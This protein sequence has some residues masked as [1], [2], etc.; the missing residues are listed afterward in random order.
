MDRKQSSN[1]YYEWNHKEEEGFKPLPPYDLADHIPIIKLFHKNSKQTDVITIKE[2]FTGVHIFGATGSGKTSGS[3]NTF[4]RAMLYNGYGGAVFTVKDDEVNTWMGQGRRTGEYTGHI[5]AAGRDGQAIIFREDSSYTFNPFEYLKRF[6]KLYKLDFLVQLVGEIYRINK[7]AQGK[8]P[9]GSKN[10][11][12][13]DIRDEAI[14]IAIALLMVSEEKINLLQIADIIDTMPCTIEAAELYFKAKKEK[15]D[16]EFMAWLD[17]EDRY[18]LFCYYKA[19]KRPNKT[20][21][22]EAR[23]RDVRRYI[24]HEF[25]EM[26]E[27]YK[28]TIKVSFKNMVSPFKDRDGIL[29]KHFTSGVS[30]EVCPERCYQD[31]AVIILD[32]PTEIHEASG[33]MIQNVYRMIWQKVMM[34][35]NVRDPEREDYNRRPVFFWMDECSKMVIPRD[36]DF[37]S[38]C[39]SKRVASVLINQNIKS[40]YAK[41]TGL[42]GSKVET[43]SFLDNL[44]IHVVHKVDAATAKWAADR[45]GKEEIEVYSSSIQVDDGRLS[46]SSRD[47]LKYIC[48][49]VDF[50]NLKPGGPENDLFTEA[51]IIV[52]NPLQGGRHFAHI[53]FDQTNMDK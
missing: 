21:N 47:Q 33:R 11:F 25:P 43:D 34:N 44:L 45:I 52:N 48:P 17:H 5:K 27:N 49:P 32:F 39:R 18:A 20:S 30:E 1:Q 22:D 46:S 7:R 38:K 9:G 29:F 42:N 36:G 26:H 31:G 40:Y 15:S 53:E 19:L 24:F 16:Y 37:F 13:D 12:W 28:G 14:R 10:E 2:T 51:I 35:R 4:A 8:N 6:P 50:I 3:G 41:L 23:L